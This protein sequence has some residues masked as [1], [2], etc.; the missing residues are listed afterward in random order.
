MHSCVT[1]ACSIC[2]RNARPKGSTSAEQS[3]LDRL[4][5]QYPDADPQLIDRIAAAVM[6][7]G[8]LPEE[9]CPRPCAH[10]SNRK[11]FGNARRHQ[12]GHLDP[13]AH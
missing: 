13:F 5:A 9:P 10:V 11:P 12:Q 6:L 4:L 8:D 1:S 3:E 7:A 2:W